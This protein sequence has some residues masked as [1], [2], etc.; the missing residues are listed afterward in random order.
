MHLPVR[1]L[2]GFGAAFGAMAF[3]VAAVVLTPQP[4]EPSMHAAKASADCP[5]TLKAQKKART[6]TGA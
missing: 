6:L 3:V 5:E 1:P 2:I 4:A